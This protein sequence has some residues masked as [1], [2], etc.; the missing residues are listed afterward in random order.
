[1]RHYRGMISCGLALLFTTFSSVSFAYYRKNVRA[2]PIGY[3]RASAM[4]RLSAYES[5]K[6]EEQEVRA[7]KDLLD[8]RIRKQTDEIMREMRRLREGRGKSIG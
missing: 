8:R 6:T 5:K 3:D 2:S 1:M 7:P 4:I